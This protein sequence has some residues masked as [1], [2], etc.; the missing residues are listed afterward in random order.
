[1]KYISVTINIGEWFL[2]VGRFLLTLQQRAA[3]IKE[4]SRWILKI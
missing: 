4:Q 2:I 1:M 3:E